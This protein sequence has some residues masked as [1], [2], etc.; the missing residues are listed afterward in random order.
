M[1]PLD[2]DA[3]AGFGWKVGA[4]GLNFPFALVGISISAFYQ[5]LSLLMVQR[6]YSLPIVFFFVI[7]RCHIRDDPRSLLLLFLVLC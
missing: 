1:L 7:R 5:L 2:P 6:T 4:V 3:S